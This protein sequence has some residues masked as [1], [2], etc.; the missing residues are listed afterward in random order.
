MFA[1]LV[2]GIIGCAVTDNYC[3]LSDIEPIYF[4]EEEEEQ[5]REAVGTYG[6]FYQD[7]I[8][9]HLPRYNQ[10]YYVPE[11]RPWPLV[12]FKD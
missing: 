5:P 1:L 9:W 2:V 11:E 10:N 4:M 6:R 7:R 12:P 8:F 3:G